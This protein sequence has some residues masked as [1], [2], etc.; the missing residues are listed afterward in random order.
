MFENAQKNSF[1]YFKY[2]HLS[3][4]ASYERD[5]INYCEDNGLLNKISNGPFLWY[6]YSGKQKRYFSDFFIEEL[7]LII[8]IKSL[9]WF[10]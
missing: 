8:E 3:Y 5:F 10:N 4:Q 7:N 1:K 9:H 6:E 2:K